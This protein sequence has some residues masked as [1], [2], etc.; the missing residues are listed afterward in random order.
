VGE[1]LRIR[2]V[3]IV[4]NIVGIGI[5]TFCLFE[6]NTHLFDNDATVIF[7]IFSSFWTIIFL[8]RLKQYSAEI[9]YQWDLNADA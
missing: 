9:K 8:E 1:S 3:H 4:I 5:M 6:D 7:S 2:S